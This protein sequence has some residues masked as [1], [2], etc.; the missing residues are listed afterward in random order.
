M[1]TIKLLTLCTVC[2]FSAAIF[3][4]NLESSPLKEDPLTRTSDTE[5]DALNLEEYEVQG[6][7]FGDSLFNLPMSAQNISAQKIAESNLVSIPEVLRSLANIY[8]RNSSGSNPNTAEISMRGF[9][10]NSSQRVLVLVDGQRINRADMAATNWAQIPLE[11]IDN[12]EILRGAQSA[13]YGNYAIGGVLKITT[14]KWNQPDSASFGGFFGSYGEYGA[15]G[16]AAHSGEDYYVSANMN[17]YHNSGFLDNSLT[18]NK[19]AGM[20]AGMK[21]DSKNEVHFSA[22]GGDEFISY[23]LYFNS[24][25]DMKKNPSS[26]GFSMEDNLNYLTISS[27]WENKSD[28]GEGGMQVGAN[29]REKDNF[30]SPTWAPSSTLWTVSAAPRYRVYLDDENG[31]HIEGGA[32]V[33]Y[34]NFSIKSD[35]FTSDIE[36]ITAAPWIAGVL[37]INEIFSMIAGGRFEAAFNDASSRGTNPYDAD[38]SVNGMAAQIGVNAKISQSW[39]VYFRFD[40]VYR[41]PSVDEMFSVWGSSYTENNLSLKPE[42]GQNYE[43]GTNF[44][45]DNWRANLSLFFMHLDDEIAYAYDPL[46]WKGKNINIGSSNRYGAEVSISYDLKHVGFSTSWAFVSAEISSGQYDGNSVPLVPSIVS[47]TRVWVQPLSFCRLELCYQWASEQ[48]LGSD[49]HN[50]YEKMP[51]IWTLDLNANFFINEN[52]RAFINF[53]NITGETYASYGFASFGSSYWY[54]GAGRTVRAGIE[55]K[56]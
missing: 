48:F 13:L 29:M 38:E 56:F 22:S 10:E 34:D 5:K 33:Y 44:A 40:Q 31:S 28:F 14:K 27:S 53:G 43:I 35:G 25:D 23:P 7:R 47:S 36:R 41:Y 52:V 2:A 49:F 18:W 11:Q 12:I 51:A 3:A 6:M 54:A 39:N 21:L 42:R 4:D 24:Y 46:T 20:S 32:D 45:H 17:Y 1:N 8:T 26:T 50:E 30:T 19:S 55:I 37:K 16:R 9:G 15:H